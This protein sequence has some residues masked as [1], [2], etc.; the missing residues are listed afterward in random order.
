VV[1]GFVNLVQ[2]LVHRPAENKKKRDELS[3]NIFLMLQE[4]NKFREH[5]AREI[6]IEVLEKQLEDKRVLL[7]ELRGGITKAD[8]LLGDTAKEVDVVQAMDE[9]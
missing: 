1:G 7:K 9:S 4:S 5:Q 8:G 2:E 3:H 6:L